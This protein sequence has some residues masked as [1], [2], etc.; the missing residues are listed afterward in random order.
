MNK[1]G[2]EI[3]VFLAL[4][5]IFSSVFWIIIIINGFQSKN[6]RAHR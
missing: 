4:T 6:A 5:L 2:R 1:K 3:V